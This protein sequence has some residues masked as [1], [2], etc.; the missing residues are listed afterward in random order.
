VTKKGDIFKWSTIRLSRRFQSQ[1]TGH[2]G[3]GPTEEDI[4]YVFRATTFLL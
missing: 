3:L 1:N 2:M 4:V